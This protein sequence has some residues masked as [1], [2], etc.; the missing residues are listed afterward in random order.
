M[1]TVVR[2]PEV[3][4]NAGQAVIQTW[5]VSEGQEI[6]VGDPL[7]EIETEKA[8]VEYVAEVWRRGRPTQ[9]SMPPC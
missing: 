5:L 9:T 1:P 4:A 6:T 3:L 8:V 7:A 2:M